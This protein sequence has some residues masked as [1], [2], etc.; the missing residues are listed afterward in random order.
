MRDIFNTVRKLYSFY[1]SFKR[2]RIVL[3]SDR[4]LTRLFVCY[5]CSVR[6]QTQR[7]NDTFVK[8]RDINI[9]VIPPLRRNAIQTRRTAY[10]F[11]RLTRELV[12]VSSLVRASRTHLVTT[13]AHRGAYEGC[14]MHLSAPRNVTRRGASCTDEEEALD[15]AAESVS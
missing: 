11:S 15:S 1:F 7:L 13:P 4:Y 12:Q 10:C 14:V 2:I 6:F 8:L 3:L 9:N 5:L